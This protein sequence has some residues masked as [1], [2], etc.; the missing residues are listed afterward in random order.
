MFATK[1]QLRMIESLPKRADFVH[2]Y[3]KGDKW[4]SKGVV[5][6]AVPGVEGRVRF[7]ITVTKKISKSAVVRNRIRRRLRAA[8]RDIFPNFAMPGFDYVLVGRAGS[9][10][11]P[12]GALKGDLKWCLKR[13]DRLKKTDGEGA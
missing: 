1:S 5:L 11:Y 4:V 7:G 6:Q 2:A 9:I 13:M 3:Q 10:E 12:Y 8:A